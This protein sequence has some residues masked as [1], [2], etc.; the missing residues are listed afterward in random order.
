M[1]FDFIGQNHLYYLQILI[2][3]LM[4]VLLTPFYESVQEIYLGDFY[5][6]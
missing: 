2:G 4:V 1:L 5:L 6:F 3:Q